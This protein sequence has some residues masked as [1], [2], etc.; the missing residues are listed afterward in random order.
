MQN[1]LN[2]NELLMLELDKNDEDENVCLITNEKLKDDHIEFICKHKFN[3]KPIFNE[4]CKQKMNYIKK[5]QHNYLE[6]QKLTKYQM[7]CPY[8]RKIQ[9]GILPYEEGYNK[10]YF[11]N[12]PPAHT[13]K[14]NICGYTFLS[15]KKKG[16]LCNKPCLK[17]YCSSHLK[18][19]NNRKLK[20]AEKEKKKK[21]TKT[22]KEKNFI[23]C[24]ALTKKGV[25]C[26]RKAKEGGFCKQHFILQQN[27]MVL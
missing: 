4:I 14:T 13:L 6:V 23:K 2:F 1:N 3:Y 10:L 27:K 15:G 7:K 24:S 8:C 26:S 18:I 12:W 21:E 19:L 5:K 11:I 22:K 9:N 16:T 25:Q 17:K 20:Q